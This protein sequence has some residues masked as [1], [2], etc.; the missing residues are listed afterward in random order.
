MHIDLLFS[1]F[2]GVVVGAFITTLVLYSLQ[3]RLLNK[4]LAATKQSQEVFADFLTEFRNMLNDRLGMMTAEMI[5][6][7]DRIAQL[8]L[9]RVSRH[10]VWEKTFPTPAFWLPDGKWSSHDVIEILSTILVSEISRAQCK[11]ALPRLVRVVNSRATIYIRITGQCRPTSHERI[12][13][14]IRRLERRHMQHAL[15][16][17]FHNHFVTLTTF[18][19]THATDNKA[20]ERSHRPA[21]VESR[22]VYRVAAFFFTLA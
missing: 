18:S 8:D 17:M 16:I 6:Q 3:N 14:L 22:R 13:G 15:Q 1:G 12:A 2:A 19:R 21:S 7:N 9:R 11:D 10:P 4:Q 5:K 20:I